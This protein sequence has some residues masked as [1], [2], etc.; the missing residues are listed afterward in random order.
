MD[1]EKIDSTFLFVVNGSFCSNT[2]DFRDI[3]IFLEAG[4]DVIAISPLGG[5][6][7]SF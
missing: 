3:E 7:N 2:H 5:A 4:N 6:V 1:S